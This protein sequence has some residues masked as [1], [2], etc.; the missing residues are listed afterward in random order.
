MWSVCSPRLTSLSCS[1]PRSED[2]TY[3]EIASAADHLT[4]K[5][6]ADAKKKVKIA[7]TKDKIMDLRLKQRVRGSIAVDTWAREISAAE[8]SL[9]SRKSKV[10][11]FKAPAWTRGVLVLPDGAHLKKTSQYLGGTSLGCLMLPNLSTSFIMLASM[12]SLGLLYNRGAPDVPKDDFGQPGEVRSPSSVS[13][14]LTC[15]LV[16]GFA[17]LSA[18]VGTA[19]ISA[20]P[21]IRRIAPGNLFVNLWINLGFWVAATFF[22][23]YRE[24]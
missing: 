11:D 20:V 7:V 10:K 12:C 2:A 23:T 1:A 3:E 5:Y 22:K 21:G 14:A 6:S 9:N 16:F 15:G 13:V 17:A 18:V 24:A 19:V 8:D 4:A